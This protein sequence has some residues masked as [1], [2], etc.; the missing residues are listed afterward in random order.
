MRKVP[1]G[2][3]R[4]LSESRR[5]ARRWK[6]VTGGDVSPNREF[7]DRSRASEELS[8]IG[9]D[10]GSP[11]EVVDAQTGERKAENALVLKNSL[12]D[13]VLLGLRTDDDG[14]DVASAIGSVAQFGFVESDNQQAAALE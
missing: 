2:L 10:G 14:G 7:A 6:E 3:S 4:W 9:R 13:I 1:C 11:G 5:R 8:H 12:R